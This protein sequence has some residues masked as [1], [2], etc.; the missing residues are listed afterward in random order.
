MSPPAGRL[1][2]V[3]A[4]RAGRRSLSGVRGRGSRS[5]GAG[6]EPITRAVDAAARAVILERYRV[7]AR[8]FDALAARRSRQPLSPAQR[9]VGG[10]AAL[11]RRERD[12]L[13]LVADGF[14]DEQIGR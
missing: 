6:L 12:V 1:S 13:R 8:A 14:T 5:S 3:L 11:S 7:R 4:L 10:E 9:R 2:R